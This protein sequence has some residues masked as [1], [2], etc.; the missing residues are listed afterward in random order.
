MA[1]NQSDGF[2][3]K[4]EIEKLQEKI[5]RMSSMSNDSDN[6]TTE[7]PE[8]LEEEIL[9]P[10]PPVEMTAQFLDASDTQDENA[11]KKP[12]KYVVT[13]EIEN[14]DYFEKL[15]VEERSE[16]FNEM[17]SE[18]IKN[19]DKIKGKKR[20]K[21]VFIHTLIALFTLIIAVPLLLF[22]I[23]MSLHLTVLNYQHAQTNFEKLY[24]SNGIPVE[25]KRRK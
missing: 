9:P 21:K 15:T 11:E 3:E 18:Y 2:N 4:E 25:P 12:K 20:A 14:L 16:L 17:L 10:A 22:L 13:A 7:V 23:N 8:E 1:D 24:E 5:K 19:E 6:F